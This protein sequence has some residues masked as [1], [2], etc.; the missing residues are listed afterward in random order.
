MLLLSIVMLV[1]IGFVIFNY[2]KKLP[3]TNQNEFSGVYPSTLPTHPPSTPVNPTPVEVQP[4]PSDLSSSVGVE[5]VTKPLTE[6]KIKTQVK[7]QGKMKKTQAPPPPSPKPKNTNKQAPKQQANK[8][9]N[10][11]K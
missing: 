3:T 2:T 10:K 5:S 9:P 6:G 11:S 8:K 4:A 7:P 1:V